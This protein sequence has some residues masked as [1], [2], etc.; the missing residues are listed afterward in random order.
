MEKVSRPSDPSGCWVW[1]AGRCSSGYGTFFYHG[2]VQP[3]NRVAW[4]LMVG[5][6][7]ADKIVCHTCD[8][9]A[10]VN[11]AHLW[12]GTHLDNA[13]DKMAKGRHTWAEKTHC[14]R[15]HLLSGDNLYI[16]PQKGGL[17]V[18]RTCARM[19]GREYDRYRRHRAAQVA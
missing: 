4:M 7:P 15:G 3:S 11:P 6:I 14:I 12:L 10:C 9:P 18:C 16:S 8:N 13:R 19:H 5:Q 1:T 2:R 17:R